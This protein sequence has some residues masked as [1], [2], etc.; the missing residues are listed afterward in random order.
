M[1]P[2]V[3]GERPGNVRLQ[4]TTL[5][6]GATDPALV[7][8]QPGAGFTDVTFAVPPNAP[9]DPANPNYLMLHLNSTT[10]SPADAGVSADDRNLG[11]QVDNVRVDVA[12]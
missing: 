5:T 10:W 11:V 3:V 7:T 6:P 1:Q 8:L 2:E 12:P 4:P 9:T